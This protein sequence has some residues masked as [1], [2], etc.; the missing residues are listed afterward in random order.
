MRLNRRVIL[1][2][3]AQGFDTAISAPSCRRAVVLRFGTELSCTALGYRLMA[4]T[5]TKRLC[6]GS[7]AGGKASPGPLADGGDG[8]I[9][10][11]NFAGLRICQEKLIE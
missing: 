2:R 10:E 11:K 8:A 7:L 4:W 3:S 9:A 5:G 1:A 6:L